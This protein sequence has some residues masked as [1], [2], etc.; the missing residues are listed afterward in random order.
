M[1]V[2]NSN[3]LEAQPSYEPVHTRTNVCRKK[4]GH[5]QQQARCVTTCWKRLMRVGFE[6]TPEDCEVD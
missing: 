2:M 1:C 6:P 5:Y 4:K 3:I